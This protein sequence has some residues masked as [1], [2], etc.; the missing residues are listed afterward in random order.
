MPHP[1]LWLFIF[2]LFSAFNSTKAAKG[3][4]TEPYF[5]ARQQE[6]YQHLMALSFKKAEHAMK[7]VRT[8][9]ANSTE[10]L[11]DNYRDV[12]RLFLS[13]SEQQ[14][15]SVKYRQEQR[16][17]QLKSLSKSSPHY[18]FTQAEVNFQ[19]ALLHYKFGHIFD[20]GS[21]FLNAYALIRENQKR[22]P[23]FTPNK[24]LLGISYYTLDALPGPIQTL[25]RFSGFKQDTDN[26]LRYLN[27][28]IEEDNFYRTEAFLYKNVIRGF[29]HKDAEPALEE[30]KKA[31][32][33]NPNNIMLS[34]ATAWLATKSA[35]GKLALQVI[36]QLPATEAPIAWVSYIKGVNLLNLGHL[37]EAD[38]ALTQFTQ[39][40]TIQSYLKDAY[41][42]RFLVNWLQG[43][44]GA[45]A[46]LDSLV[47]KGATGSVSDKYAQQFAERYFKTKQL[48]NRKLTQA[49]LLSDGGAVQKALT[50]LQT[51]TAA[52]L[53]T[54]PDVT[55]YHYRFGRLHQQLE[56]WPQA[57]AEF[58][59][60]I[61]AGQHLP[62]YFAANAA[63]QSM[64]SSSSGNR[65][66]K[67][68]N[69]P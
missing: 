50:V 11:L 25:A 41:F 10:L 17:V 31:I 49:R 39:H 69:K 18:L 27:S 51:T 26:G 44:T 3:G 34:L 57:Q 16:L 24:K 13:D 14:Y 20:A 23:Q 48:P 21:S 56:Q 52:E 62:Q 12:L 60:A 37:A 65:R 47:S 35:Q 6:A 54:P 7:Q 2:A 43:K 22:Y 19:W 64:Q 66:C 38:V 1:R 29:L 55:E 9:P 30:L 8:T 61:Q 59:L 15:D 4:I 42:R 67:W 68:H 45:T 28:V 58:K 5:S 33:G 40:P 63:L 36:E 46:L 32:S 53:P